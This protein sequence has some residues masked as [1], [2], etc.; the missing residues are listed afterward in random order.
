MNILMLLKTK[1][2]K[3]WAWEVFLLWQNFLQVGFSYWSVLGLL[4]EEVIQTQ[5][6]F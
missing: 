2:P 3:F 1:E 5:N 4:L 6:F